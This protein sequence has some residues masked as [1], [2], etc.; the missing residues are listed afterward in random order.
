MKELIVHIKDSRG[1]TSIKYTQGIHTIEYNAE[2]K[3]LSVVLNRDYVCEN[4]SKLC[5][6]N[7]SCEPFKHTFYDVE[8]IAVS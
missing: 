1:E 2:S 8:Y 6:F 5:E 3:K 4:K 7:T